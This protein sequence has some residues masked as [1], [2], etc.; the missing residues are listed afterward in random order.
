MA[1][2]KML[3]EAQERFFEML[4]DAGCVMDIHTIT[5]SQY[6]DWCSDGEPSE[7]AIDKAEGVLLKL[8][9]KG[10]AVRE[11]EGYRAVVEANEEFVVKPQARRIPGDAEA[12]LDELKDIVFRLMT[13]NPFCLQHTVLQIIIRSIRMESSGSHARLF[14]KIV[15]ENVPHLRHRAI[16]CANQESAAERI[17]NHERIESVQPD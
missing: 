7:A 4:R 9:D 2:V 8:I 3:T 13:T 16:L 5:T 1:Q 14:A 12:T 15:G 10:F 11:G 17:L 6:P